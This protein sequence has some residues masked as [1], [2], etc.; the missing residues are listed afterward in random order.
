[1][2]ARYRAT[3]TQHLQHMGAHTFLRI[4]RYGD[5]VDYNVVAHASD[6][7]Y[8]AHNQQPYGYAHNV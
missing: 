6:E 4:G 3:D 8:I 7:R 2:F 1:L 5:A